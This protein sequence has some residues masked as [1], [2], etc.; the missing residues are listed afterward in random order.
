[1]S[2]QGIKRKEI[3]RKFIHFTIAFVP[4]LARWNVYATGVLLCLGILFYIINETARV[5]GAD[6][7][8]ISQITEIASRPTEK[9]FVWGPVTLGIGGLIAMLFYPHPATTLAI[10]ALAFGDGVASLAGQLGGGRRIPGMKEK[11]VI[12]SLA[13]FI[14]VFT[15]ALIYLKIFWLAV[16]AA[17]LTTLLE[18]LPLKCFDN[19]VIPL[20]TGMVFY[21]IL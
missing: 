3:L 20:C 9:G 11:T 16:L 2:T 19:V 5:V 18:L 14:V 21:L 17:V 10:Y 15:S 13:C 12:G 7:G 1:M 8:L 4:A 6:Y